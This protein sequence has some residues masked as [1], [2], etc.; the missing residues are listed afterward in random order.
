MRAK[1]RYN[2]A[3]LYAHAYADKECFDKILPIH[4]VEQLGI[5]FTDNPV[6]VI[7][8]EFALSKDVGYP[9]MDYSTI[10]E[11]YDVYPH[12]TIDS[13]TFQGLL[14]LKVRG[15]FFGMPSW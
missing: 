2:E 3:I 1:E 8:K 14:T 12:L 10:I 15:K 11:I 5:K 13:K 9:L 7:T 4:K 6:D